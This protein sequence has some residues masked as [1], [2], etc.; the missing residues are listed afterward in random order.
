MSMGD[1][2]DMPCCP[3]A[4]EGKASVA[5]VFK[6]LNFVATVFPPATILSHVANQLPS[7]FGDATLHGH[8]SRPIHPPPI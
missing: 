8:V 3:P 1:Q 2:V 7:S 4:D 6:C 5:C